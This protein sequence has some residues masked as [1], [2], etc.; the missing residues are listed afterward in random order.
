M[1]TNTTLS[2]TYQIVPLPWPDR[3]KHIPGAVDEASQLAE[4]IRV[5][6]SVQLGYLADGSSYFLERSRC[7]IIILQSL[8][9]FWHSACPT[10]TLTSPLSSAGFQSRYFRTNPPCAFD[11]SPMNLPRFSSKN[12]GRS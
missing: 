2:P 7:L 6:L 11:G 1:S 10:T 3:R 9:I 4:D 5:F 12:G 8:V